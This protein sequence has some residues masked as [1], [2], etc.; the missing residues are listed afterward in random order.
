MLTSGYK[1]EDKASVQP[2]Q[3]YPQSH[4]IACPSREAVLDQGKA[5]RAKVAG[6]VHTMSH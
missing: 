2:E 1:P 5:R 3:K 4:R 6:S